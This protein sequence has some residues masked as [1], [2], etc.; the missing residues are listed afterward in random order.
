MA[1]L[2]G[3]D[4]GSR[5]VYVLSGSLLRSAAGYTAVVYTDSA[6]TILANIA[7][8]QP[9]VP[10][11][12]GAVIAGST[13][14][15]D[16][17]SRLPLF[18]FPDGVPTGP[19]T[20]YVRVGGVSS[21]VVP[22]NADYD[23][24]IDAL[25]G[26]GSGTPS[27]TVVTET[28]FGQA[29]TAGAGTD[30]SRGDHS[31][32]TPAAPTAGSVGADPAGTATSAVA[33]HDADATAVHGISDTSLLV[34]GPMT[35]TDNAI[36]RFDLTTGKLIQNSLASVDDAGQVAAVGGAFSSDVT[37]LGSGKGYRLRASG[38][39]LDFDGTGAD[40]FLS[41][42]SGTAFDGTQR[43]YAR[44]E[45][46]ATLL[47][48]IGRIE[49]AASAFG[50]SVHALDSVTGVAEIGAKN[51]LSNVQVSG[52]RATPGAPTTGTWAAGDTVQD[53]SGTWFLCT[54]GGTPGTWVRGGGPIVS[55]GYVT[56]GDQTLTNVG[57]TR[58]V[59]PTLGAFTIPAVA[60]DRIE[61]QLSFLAV[62]AGINHLDIAVITSGTQVRYA[63]TG[64][65]T[66]A[67][68]G[69]PNMYRASGATEVRGSGLFNFTA[70]A[71]DIAGGNVTFGLV[72]HGT[73]TTSTV[74][75]STNY[76]FRW[77]AKN[78]GPA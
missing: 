74:F 54:V 16:S 69:D 67:V 61:I 19:D 71:G 5:L 1:R 26:G 41:V 57:A 12:P 28:A 76:P 8:Y 53:S 51:S 66:P 70:A 47:H 60:G 23:P 7:A 43:T 45:S 10:G 13:L 56:A 72:Y 14:T 3:P 63:S 9:L 30:Y 58:T 29:S 4:A 36:A 64:T 6:G 55:F 50:A 49:F 48:L 77:S 17:T 42:F 15:V 73:G 68:E 11:T 37:V 35:S 32:G 34:F 39:A 44:F 59:V 40:L 65:G 38:G 18:W 22:I 24:R 52:R 21:P 25:I 27:A 78:F 31:H 62:L 33:A 46:G 2:I 75:A 20:L